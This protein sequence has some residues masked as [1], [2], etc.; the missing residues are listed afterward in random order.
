MAQNT[1]NHVE[2]VQH[3]P[4]SEHGRGFPPFDPQTFASQLVWLTLTFVALYLL[5]S[6]LALPRVSSILEQRRRHIDTDLAEAQ[7]LKGESD[8][9]VA[10]H[11]KALAQARERAQV[12]AG[13]TREK[14]A[15]AAEA[16]RKALD[17]EL[18]AHIAEAEKAIAANRSTAMSN[19]RGIASDAAAAIVERLTGAA[20]TSQDVTD[21]V[22]RT[23]K[24]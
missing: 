3:V 21:A 13:A 23:L 6:R 17:V 22:E 24:V 15:A 19:V 16:R 5:M 1:G 12:L 11:E 9:A 18:G 2:A 4:A 20:P 7:R 8:A 14:A 10:S